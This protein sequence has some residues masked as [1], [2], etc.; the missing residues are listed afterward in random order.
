MAK[1][2]KKKRLRLHEIKITINFYVISITFKF[3]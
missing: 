2:K 3:S 1:H